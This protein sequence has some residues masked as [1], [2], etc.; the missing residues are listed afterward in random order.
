MTYALKKKMIKMA[1]K[2]VEIIVFEVAI[3]MVKD[4]AENKLYP[5]A[6][7]KWDEFVAKKK[8]K[9]NEDKVVKFSKKHVG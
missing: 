1:V 3:P 9:H 7:K 8:I 6:C 4:F 2:G 5:T